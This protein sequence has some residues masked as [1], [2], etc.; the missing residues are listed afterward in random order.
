MA[1]AV[2]AVATLVVAVEL[3]SLYENFLIPLPVIGRGIFFG[4]LQSSLFP[5]YPFF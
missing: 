1:V 5:G 3:N 4:N 2:A